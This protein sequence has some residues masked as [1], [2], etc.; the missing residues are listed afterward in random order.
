MSLTLQKLRSIG[1]RERMCSDARNLLRSPSLRSEHQGDLVAGNAQDRPCAS[2]AE[3]LA[4]RMAETSAGA[5]AFSCTGEPATSDIDDAVVIRCFG[6]VR[7]VEEL[8]SG[9]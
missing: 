4:R 8:L 1:C 9:K 3:S 5:F 7:T 6:E 2:A